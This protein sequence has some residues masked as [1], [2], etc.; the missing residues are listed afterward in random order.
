MMPMMSHNDELTDSWDLPFFDLNAIPKT[1]LLLGRA[2]RTKDERGR[3]ATEE[4][5]KE[6]EKEE[7]KL[8]GA[9]QRKR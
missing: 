8:G 5:E 4:K 3:E 9:R 1:S 6:E 7:E 2:L